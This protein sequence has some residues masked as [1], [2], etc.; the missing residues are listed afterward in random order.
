MK[1]ELNSAEEIRE[2]SIKYFEKKKKK[3]LKSFLRDIKKSI[4][5]AAVTGRYNTQ[6]DFPKYLEKETLSI[7]KSKGYIVSQ[8]DNIFGAYNSIPTYI[9]S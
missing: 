9:V 1:V 7:L 6:V 4:N 2:L 3:E 8:A 5:Y